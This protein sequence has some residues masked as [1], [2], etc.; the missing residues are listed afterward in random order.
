M[1]EATIQWGE[2]HGIGSAT[3][4]HSAVIS[5]YCRSATGGGSIVYG[6]Q[7]PILV[8]AATLGEW[9]EAELRSRFVRSSL[10]AWRW[11]QRRVPGSRTAHCM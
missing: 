6:G 1:P 5:H 11:Q 2:A 3:D 8:L 7:R 10:R 4:V 9:K